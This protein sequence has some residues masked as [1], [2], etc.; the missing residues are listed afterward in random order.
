M[1]DWIKLITAENPVEAGF[2]SGLLESEGI[3][4]RLRN[5]EL[6]TAA[7]EIYFAAGARPSVWVRECEANQARRVLDQRDR[8][9]SGSGWTCRRCGEELDGQFTTCWH[10]GNDREDAR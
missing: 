1:K 3:D 7:V 6:W 10:C 2:L 8:S 5:M 9:N 4:T